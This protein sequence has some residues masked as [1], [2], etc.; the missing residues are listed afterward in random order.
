MTAPLLTG[1]AKTALRLEVTT[2][3][4]FLRTRPAHQVSSLVRTKATD[5]GVPVLLA[6]LNRVPVKQ[7]SFDGI[8]YDCIIRVEHGKLEYVPLAL[9]VFDAIPGWTGVAKEPAVAGV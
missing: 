4:D 3:E 1:G 9:K 8:G 5:A 2:V 7:Q 6:L